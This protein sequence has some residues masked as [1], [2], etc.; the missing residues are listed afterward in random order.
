MRALNYRFNKKS[1]IYQFLD[2]PILPYIFFDEQQ[3]LPDTRPG[4]LYEDLDE[5]LATE[6]DSPSEFV[7]QLSTSPWILEE[8]YLGHI[9]VGLNVR[10]TMP[11]QD[12]KWGQ[13]GYMVK[14]CTL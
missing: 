4:L 6:T 9:V 7:N 2:V 1:S 14:M 3:P 11:L 5:I 13:M 8:R 10:L 12:P